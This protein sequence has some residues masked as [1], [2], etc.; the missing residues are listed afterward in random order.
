M[1]DTIFDNP[2]ECEICGR[3]G[4]EY[5]TLGQKIYREYL[6][7]TL[8]IDH[9]SQA[10]WPNTYKEINDA[11]RELIASRSCDGD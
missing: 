7:K 5:N 1:A 8:C 6:G 11:V 2:K 9:Y 4:D 3:R 10:K